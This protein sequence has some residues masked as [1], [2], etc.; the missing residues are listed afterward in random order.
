MEN[1]FIGSLVLWGLTAILVL[2]ITNLL[3]GRKLAAAGVAAGEVEKL[4]A[5]EKEYWQSQFT[6]TYILEH[7]AVC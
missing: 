1:V 4:A 3:L 2:P 5:G 7:F 6:Q